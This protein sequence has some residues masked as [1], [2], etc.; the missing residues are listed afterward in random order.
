M[1]A[2]EMELYAVGNMILQG[3]DLIQY[4]NISTLY[5]CKGIG[6]ACSKVTYFVQGIYMSPALYN[7]KDICV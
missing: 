5:I 7:R 4:S 3:L 1:F 6:T 2:Q